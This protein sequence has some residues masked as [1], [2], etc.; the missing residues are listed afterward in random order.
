M[1]KMNNLVPEDWIACERA[2]QAVVDR[3][4]FSMC[5][6]LN[7]F[8]SMGQN[9]DSK[10]SN[11]S[12]AAGAAGRGAERWQNTVPILK[13]NNHNSP[14]VGILHLYVEQLKGSTKEPQ[15]IAKLPIVNSL[16][17]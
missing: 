7:S 2:R 12:S 17:P 11:E 16:L 14:N 6:D 15:E 1:I 9:T 3:L 13:P 5:W 8:S 4:P 10:A